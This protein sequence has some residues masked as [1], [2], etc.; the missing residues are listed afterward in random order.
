[1]NDPGAH[2]QLR[3]TISVPL[4]GLQHVV[5]ALTLYHS[6]ADTYSSDHLRILL[7]IA[8]KVAHSVENALAFQEAESSATTDYLTE[9]PNARS[10]FLHLDRELARCK[11]LNTPI[12][13]MVC[14]LDGFKRI[15]DS[16]GH[17][18]GNKILKLFAK[19]LQGSCRE[20]D[21][22]ARMGGDEF[23]IVAPGLSATAAEAKGICLS[24]LARVAGREVCGEDW[25]SLSVG[26]SF[27]PHDGDEAE[28]LLAE[29]DR[30]M[31]LQKQERKDLTHINQFAA[32]IRGPALSTKDIPG[33]L[34]T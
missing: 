29:A 20:Y 27:Y 22:I 12:T 10:L 7:A 18:E 3:S 8:P 14:D 1:L 16:Y 32:G 33:K 24:E 23:V 19:T 11:R 13:V 2:A 4:Q 31:Y 5:G 26:C 34:V 21:Y 25:L 9:L 30:R 17:L 6:L 15:N 28:Q